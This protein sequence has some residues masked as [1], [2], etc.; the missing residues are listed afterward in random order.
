MLFSRLL[1]PIVSYTYSLRKVR[2]QRQLTVKSDERNFVARQQHT[3][4][5]RVLHLYII[6]AAAIVV[7]C[8]IVFYRI[9]V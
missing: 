7:L 8:F 5:Y 9:I 1:P 6:I 3:D 4:V 2:Q